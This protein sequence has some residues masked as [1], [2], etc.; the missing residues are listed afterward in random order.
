MLRPS[1]ATRSVVMILFTLV[2]LALVAAPVAVLLLGSVAESWN[3]VLPGSFTGAHLS[4]A[5][6]GENLQS[7]SVSVQTALVASLLS[8]VV[9]TWAALA[10]RALPDRAR[11]AV[12]TV[13]HLPAAVPSVVVGLGV[14]V[15]FS[16]PPLMLAGT[17]AIVILA[18]AALVLSFAYSSVSGAVARLDP[19]PARAARSLGASSARV[20]FRVELPLLLPAVASAFGLAVALCMGELGATVM[21]YPPTWRT[22]PV[23]VFALTDRGDLFGAAATA[24]V[25]IGVTV[26]VLA[27]VDLARR[28]IRT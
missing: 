20:L 2:V 25:L 14:L 17:P 8:V 15:A 19:A 28:R 3:S 9:G 24:L 5:L 1:A 4:E 18:Q 22:L 23:S 12:D 21:V 10:A 26:V 7:V 6:T 13:L 11:S 27:L 16:G